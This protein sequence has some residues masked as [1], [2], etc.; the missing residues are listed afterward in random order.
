M[1]LKLVCQPLLHNNNIITFSTLKLLNRTKFSECKWNNIN[2]PVLLFL[3]SAGRAFAIAGFIV[4]HTGPTQQQAKLRCWTWNITFFLHWSQQRDVGLLYSKLILFQLFWHIQIWR[5]ATW[6]K[7]DFLFFFNFYY[8]VTFCGHE[9]LL[10]K[11]VM[12]KEWTNYRNYSPFRPSPRSPLGILVLCSDCHLECGKFASPSFTFWNYC[13]LTYGRCQ[14]AS[15]LKQKALS[16]GRCC[17]WHLLEPRDGFFQCQPCPLP[18]EQPL[19]YSIT[20]LCCRLGYQVIL[21]RHQIDVPML[22][23]FV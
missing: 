17:S 6:D 15:I 12:P 13:N 21:G 23:V 22:F 10:E 16:M 11:T 2:C 3:W 7:S 5:M 20:P 4:W 18:V 19:G 14:Q 9:P 1:D 8:I